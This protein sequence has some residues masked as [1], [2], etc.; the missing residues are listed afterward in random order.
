MATTGPD[1]SSMAWM[2]AR[3]AQAVL[4]VMLHRLDDDDGVVDHDAD[5]QHQPEQRQ[6]VEAETD[7]AM[8]AKVPMIAT[9]TA[10]SGIIADRQFCRNRAPPPPPG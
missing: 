5:R 1:T 4:D 3:A 2:V 10:T 6:V 8:A 9:G 7:A